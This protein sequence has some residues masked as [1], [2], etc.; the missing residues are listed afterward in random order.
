[1]IL[2]GK[3]RKDFI[4]YHYNQVDFTKESH[5]EN[6]EIFLHQTEVTHQ[7]ASIIEWLDS[8][9]IYVETAIWHREKG[10]MYWGWQIGIFERWI[11]NSKKSEYNS[12]HQATEKAIER[13]VL[14]FN[15]RSER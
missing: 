10:V 6:Y 5:E 14:L 11:D 9:G 13:A 2:T 1:M 7:L 3:A 15:E 12:R 4:E 8:V